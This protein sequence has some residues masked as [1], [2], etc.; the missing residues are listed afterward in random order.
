MANKLFF[1]KY[2]WAENRRANK[3]MLELIF[4]F[5]TLYL[6]GCCQDGTRMLQV[7]GFYDWSDYQ[8][9]THRHTPHCDCWQGMQC[10]CVCFLKS[11]DRQKKKKMYTFVW[12]C[13]SEILHPILCQ[14]KGLLISQCW[15]H[16]E[17]CV[18][19]GAYAWKET[20]AFSQA[21]CNL[22]GSGFHGGHVS[23]Q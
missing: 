3:L 19:S 4:L 8:A 7:C 13:I 14:I 16:P 17:I 22:K 21:Q 18:L 5:F 10:F 6:S 15:R 11:C 9:E 2:H 1:V 23:K 20:M 12:T